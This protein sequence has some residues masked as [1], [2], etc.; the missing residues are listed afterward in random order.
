M[1]GQTGALDESQWRPCIE[2]DGSVSETQRTE[3]FARQELELDC[4]QAD[5]TLSQGG[6]VHRA[7]ATGL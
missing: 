2:R 4:P 6:Y 7:L 3:K 5:D 1:A